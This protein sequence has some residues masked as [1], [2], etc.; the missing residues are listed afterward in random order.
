M[1]LKFT[2]MIENNCTM[3]TTILSSSTGLKILI[4]MI[5]RTPNYHFSLLTENSTLYHQVSDS[6]FSTSHFT[7]MLSIVEAVK[8]F[9]LL[10]VACMLR[11]SQLRHVSWNPSIF[12]KFNV[13]RS[14]SVASMVCWIVAEDTF[15]KNHRLLEH[16]CS[17][18]R[19]TCPST[20]RS[21][22]QLIFAR[23]QED[24][25]SHS[26]YSITGKSSRE[27]L[28]SHHRSPI[29]SCKILAS[30]R[31]WRRVCQI[32]INT[33][34]SCKKFKTSLRQ[35]FFSFIIF[36]IINFYLVRFDLNLLLWNETRKKRTCS[37]FDKDQ[38]EVL[39]NKLA[40]VHVL[41]HLTSDFL[42][43]NNTIKLRKNKRITYFL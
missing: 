18:S 13:Q 23:T 3:M 26:A 2:M 19:H 37:K 12:A 40:L 33:T 42:R 41:T 43:E 25:P 17:S 28:L 11:L 7:L 15:S 32:W 14:L 38:W 39:Q 31:V 27:I 16:P 24:R 8:S 30:V 21:V 20:S 29:R 6:T 5:L 36:H 34:I 22:S 9:Q 4:I 1:L 35:L 10:V